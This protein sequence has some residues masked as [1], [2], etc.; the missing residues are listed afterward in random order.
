MTMGSRMKRRR[1][2]LDI[3][4][5][6]IADALNV[7]IATVYRYENGDIEKVPGYILAPLAQVL[8]TTPDYLM[9]WD[10][11]PFGEIEYLQP[12]PNRIRELR[13]EKKWTMKELGS[14]VGLAESTIS[15]YET[16]KRQPDN[17]TLLCFADLFDTTVDYILGRL[18]PVQSVGSSAVRLKTLRLERDLTMAD[19]ARDLGLPYTTYVNY[20][21]G[22]RRPNSEMLIKIAD[23]YHTS[24]DYVIGKGGM[25]SSQSHVRI[26]VLGSVPAGIPIEAVEDVIDWEDISAT[27]TRGGKE[28]FALR[29][30]GDS[31][32]PK[33]LDGDIVIVHRT[34]VCDSGDDC[35]VYVNGYDATLKTVFLS[36]DGGL[37]LRPIN[38]NYEPRSFTRAEVASLP[39]SIAGVVVEL[40]RKVKS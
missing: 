2:E 35:V 30:A 23:Y 21:K 4:V 29:V 19:V 12:M 34:P 3:P 37:S 13:K 32:F 27:M 15:Q 18:A 1:R 20:E 39:V 14:R 16:G 5:E 26:P 28:Y 24:V 6:K 9:G 38:T 31:M 22:E 7:S 10:K 40:R 17:K 25:P 11:S 36:K 8:Q 33:F